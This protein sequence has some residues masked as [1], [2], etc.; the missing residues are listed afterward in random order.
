MRYIRVPHAWVEEDGK[1]Y[2]TDLRISPFTIEAYHASYMDYFDDGVPLST[3]V[4]TIITKSGTT[5]NL[6]MS[7]QEFEEELQDFEKQ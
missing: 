7:I 1:I 2:S 3:D 6:L 5:Y 4:T